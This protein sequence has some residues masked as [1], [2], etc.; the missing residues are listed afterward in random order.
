MKILLV[1][2]LTFEIYELR[3][4]FAVRLGWLCAIDLYVTTI[5]SW[6]VV[7]YVLILKCH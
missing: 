6:C 7:G 5:T 4:L 1:C 3:L 2:R